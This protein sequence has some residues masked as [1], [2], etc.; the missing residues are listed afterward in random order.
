MLTFS[1]AAA[2]EFSNRLQGLLGNADH[3]VEIKTFHSYCFDFLGKI[4]N[5][6]ESDNIVKDA[7]R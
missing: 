4:G 2:M 1:R 5:I 7:P 3:F 6:E